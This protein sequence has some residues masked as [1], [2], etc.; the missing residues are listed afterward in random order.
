MRLKEAFFPSVEISPEER[1]LIKMNTVLR[2]TLS[3]SSIG[4]YKETKT[5]II[6]VKEEQFLS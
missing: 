2:F 6:V 5:E 4:N 3:R 1:R